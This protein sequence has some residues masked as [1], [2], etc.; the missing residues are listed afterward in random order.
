[1]GIRLD[2]RAPHPVLPLHQ[3]PLL[4]PL[5]LNIRHR[6]PPA[7]DPA[8]TRIPIPHLHPLHRNRRPLVNMHPPQRPADPQ[9]EHHEPPLREPRAP[10]HVGVDHV[11]QVPPLV[12][13]Q[14]DVH[15]LAALVG[16]AA[17]GGDGVVDHADDVGDVGE[18][19]V[20]FH[21]AHGGREGLGAEGAADLLEGEGLGGGGVLDEV[22]VGEA[23]LECVSRG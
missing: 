20:G 17:V 11:L 5:L 18:E 13:R 23:A 16:A 4:L 12:V 6:R 10:H 2:V 1:M 9:E 3:R 8:P 15:R 14:Q 21:L 22:D 19:A 7:R